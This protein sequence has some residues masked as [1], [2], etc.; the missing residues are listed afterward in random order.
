[1][2]KERRTSAKGEEIQNEKKVG[3][4]ALT[5]KGG[6]GRKLGERGGD[7]NLRKSNF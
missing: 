2:D 7:K 6:Y 1:M 5:R 4:L 3:S